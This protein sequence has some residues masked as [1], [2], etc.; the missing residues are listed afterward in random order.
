MTETDVVNAGVMTGEQIT[1]ASTALTSAIGNV[2]EQ[3]I[4]LLPVIGVT[5][6]AVF[7]IRFIKNRFKK[8][9]HLG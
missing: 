5:V 8:V 4:D 2:V 9:E 6:A 3:F 7:G 1:E